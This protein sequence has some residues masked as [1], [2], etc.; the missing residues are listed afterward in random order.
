MP[1]A[2]HQCVEVLGRAQQILNGN[3]LTFELTPKGRALGEVTGATEEVMVD[4]LGFAAPD[5]HRRVDGLD[6]V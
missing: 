4:G 6:P 2:C 1:G 3:D 5:T